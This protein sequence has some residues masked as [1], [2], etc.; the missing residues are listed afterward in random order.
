MLDGSELSHDRPMP[1]MAHYLET[2]GALKIS[3][4]SPKSHIRWRGTAQRAQ[5][6]DAD[7]ELTLGQH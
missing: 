5:E 2:L 3:L 4:D 6:V 7:R 1:S